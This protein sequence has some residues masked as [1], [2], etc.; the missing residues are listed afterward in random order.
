MKKN[1]YRFPFSSLVK[2]AAFEYP[3]YNKEEKYRAI[4]EKSVHAF[5]LTASNG[6][7]LETNPA[8][9]DLFGYTPKE[10]LQLNSWNIIDHTGL[11][12]LAADQEPEIKDFTHT[13]GIGIKKNGVRFPVEIS[14]STYRDINGGSSCSIM[15]SD[16]SL[17]KK[18]ESALQLSNERY[19]LVVKATKDL[20]WDWDLVS[21][22]IYRNGHN[23][24]DLYGQGSN[25]YI[26]KIEGWAEHIHPQDKEKIKAQI[27]YYIDS[28]GE[29]DF[30]LEY[31][32]KKEDG[33]YVYINDKGYIIR[34]KEGK[35]IR[36]I[37]AAADISERK[38]TALAIEESEQRYKMFVQQSTEGIWRIEVTEVLD[39]SVPLE[40]MI[41]H[42]FAY[43]Y[44]AECN[45]AYAQMYGFAKAADLIGIP[46]N[47][48]WPKENPVSIKYITGFIKNGF[49]AKEEIS[50]EYNR[51]GEQ[52]I[53]MNTMVGIVE[54]NFL[55]RVWGT[56]RNITDQK[57]AEKALA[58]SD[59]H[60][61]TI[62]NTNPECI[63]LLARD[64]TVLEMNPAGLAILEAASID[65]VVGKNVCSLVLPPY[66]EAFKK[67]IQDV[68]E[69]KA[70]ELEFELTGFKGKRCYMETHCV[71]LRDTNDNIIALLSVTREIT[72]RKN[73][74][75][76]L[77]ASE[78]RYR[79]LFNN[80][81]SNIIIWDL[82][83]YSILEVN[84]SAIDL[85]GYTREEFLQKTVLDIRAT[86]EHSKLASLA[87]EAAKTEGFKK[88]ALFETITKKGARLFM[89]ITAYKILY[90]GKQ[91]ILA[92]GNNITERIQLENS[93]NAEREIRQQ[94]ITEAVITGQEIERTE[95]GE[96]LHDNINQI[97]ASTKLY[98][99]C[100]IKDIDPRK[101]LI[102]KSKILIEK[103]MKE[104]RNLS[105]SLIPPSL[106]EIGLL[107]ALCDL[108]EHIK[109]ANELCISIDWNIADE[110]NISN[111]LKLTIFRIAQEQLNNVI[112]HA[113][114]K[115]VIISITET[116]LEMEMR[117]KD[118]GLGFNT[119]LKRNGVGLRNISSRAEVNN[120]KVSII[121]TPGEGCELIVKFPLQAHLQKTIIDI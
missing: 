18:T 15:I 116:D 35:A 40:D 59:N 117:V 57:K 109:Q 78:E 47:K 94:Q 46:L 77:V 102:A 42:C 20:V 27:E 90:N 120:G 61:R 104:I 65:Q 115:N 101:D 86:E 111:K 95:L 119:G 71:P 75:A 112:K 36:M 43:A 118:D 105:R 83:D 7:I 93:L 5:F 14:Y 29:T 55:K 58:D 60:L 8:A 45:D 51:N 66:R 76:L 85:F 25:E 16:I 28:A 26:G 68:F 100:A 114:A 32:F 106:G 39:I 24:S 33:V 13:E 79:Y 63:K 62:I 89:D 48:L 80:S 44:I 38:K 67:L 69:G 91:V 88:S 81:P 103:A 50:Y 4:I 99:E 37:G 72:E 70:A 49:K 19:N 98:I 6:I 2:T 84:Q 3:Q 54:G 34:N 21:G 92:Q 107:Q 53:F 96:E 30:D 41:E 97:L 10:F 87:E 108:V 64:G 82:N 17:R 56:R 73:A 74:Q 113:D 52:V 121:S 1:N 9:S 31:R 22:Q 11:V 12:L 23:I 110:N